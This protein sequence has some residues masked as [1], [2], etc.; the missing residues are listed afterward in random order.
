MGIDL[1]KENRELKEKLKKA[2]EIN[3]QML[4]ELLEVSKRIREYENLRKAERYIPWK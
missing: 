1:E 2:D 3:S 4:T